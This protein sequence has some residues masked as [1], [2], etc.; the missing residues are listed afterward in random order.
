MKIAFFLL[1]IGFLLTLAI[2]F[3]PVYMWI[4]IILCL[5]F[6]T[7]ISRFERIKI[8]MDTGEKLTAGEV[9]SE[10]VS[11]FFG[12]GNYTHLRMKTLGF[13]QVFLI[14]A[15]AVSVISTLIT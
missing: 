15:A 5:I 12:L 14:L 10:A 7:F 8:D 3:A 13:A 4:L 11:A 1:S 9:M 2:F 6:I